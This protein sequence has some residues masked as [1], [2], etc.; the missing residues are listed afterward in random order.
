[1]H[2]KHHERRNNDL[3]DESHEPGEWEAENIRLRP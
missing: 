2:W 3:M 1:M